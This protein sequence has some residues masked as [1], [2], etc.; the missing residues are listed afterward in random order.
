M[1][2]PKPPRYIG[3]DLPRACSRS[4]PLS[5]SVGFSYFAGVDGTPGQAAAAQPQYAQR[6]SRA[7]ELMPHL[8]PTNRIAG[9]V[10][11]DLLST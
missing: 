9:N 8:L 3:H 5:S 1:D 6:L 2:K 7:N 11:I 10:L 4:Q